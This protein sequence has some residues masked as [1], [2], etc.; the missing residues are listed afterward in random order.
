MKLRRTQ[1]EHD[2]S[3][4]LDSCSL[5]N[6][7]DDVTTVLKQYM[8]HHIGPNLLPFFTLA[9]APTLIDIKPKGKKLFQ[10]SDVY[11]AS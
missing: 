3:T 4:F 2:A 10:Y 1:H 9:A 5:Q 6:C 7:S 11:K 8:A